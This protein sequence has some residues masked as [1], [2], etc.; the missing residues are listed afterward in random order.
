MLVPGPE[1]EQA[2]RLA[3]EGL[4]ARFHPVPFGDIWLRDIAPAGENA[5]STAPPAASA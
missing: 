1:H 5:R 2:A 3:L 4:D